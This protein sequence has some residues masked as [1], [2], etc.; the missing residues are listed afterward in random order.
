MPE[1]QQYVVS[2]DADGNP[3][4]IGFQNQPQ[5]G[6]DGQPVQQKILMF[7]GMNVQGV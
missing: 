3:Q 5:V 7:Q 4:L 6:L 2:Q 1:G